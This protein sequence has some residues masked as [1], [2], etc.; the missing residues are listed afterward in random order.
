MN[1]SQAAGLKWKLDGIVENQLASVANNPSRGEPFGRA[2]WKPHLPLRLAIED[3]AAP[4]RPSPSDWPFWSSS[5]KD[6]SHVQYVLTHDTFF[7]ILSM[8]SIL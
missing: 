5:V 8:K 4:L 2:P 1:K 6:I 7:L 3:A